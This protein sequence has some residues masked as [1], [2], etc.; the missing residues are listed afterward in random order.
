[1][2][3]V[4]FCRLAAELA[5]MPADVRRTIEALAAGDVA[6]AAD[7]AGGRFSD[8]WW[9]AEFFVRRL[10]DHGATETPKFT[11]AEPVRRPRTASL[12]SDD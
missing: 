11:A 1:M 8:D 5:D 9:R 4:Q 2:T 3:A 7:H 12:F 10:A 6:R